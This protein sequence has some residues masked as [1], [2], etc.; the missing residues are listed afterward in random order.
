MGC[1][2]LLYLVDL[3]FFFNFLYLVCIQVG[4]VARALLYFYVIANPSC[5]AAHRLA[6]YTDRNNVNNVRTNLIP[7]TGITA[8]SQRSYSHHMNGLHWTKKQ[9]HIR[10]KKT[11]TR[12]K[13]QIEH[14]PKN[15]FIRKNPSLIAPFPKH[16]S[17]DNKTRCSTDSG[18]IR[19]C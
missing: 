9:K 4:H 5:G 12:G 1:I 2:S 10:T 13:S 16:S 11:N 19:P 6:M 14:Y 8:Q 7:P 15:M 17:S 18:F 3:Y